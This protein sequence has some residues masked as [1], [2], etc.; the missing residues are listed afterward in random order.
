VRSRLYLRLLVVALLVLF[1]PVAGVWS[2][3][4]FEKE[5]LAAEERAMATQARTFAA[6]L[7]PRLDPAGAL[8]SR[9]SEARAALRGVERPLAGRVRVVAADGALLAD[10]ADVPVSTTSKVPESSV[11]DRPLYRIGALLWS[12]RRMFSPA[13]QAPSKSDGT[14]PGDREAVAA[15]LGGGYGAV[16]RP[17]VD[18]TDTVLTVAVPIRGVPPAVAELPPA[19][20]VGAVVVSR[21]TDTVLAALDRIRIDLFRVV[22]L[23]LVATFLIALLLARGLV[24]P[25]LRLRDAAD[26]ALAAPS[27]V[28]TPV[29]EIER[30]DEIGEVAR[31]LDGLQR[32]LDGRLGQLESFA[33]DLAHE[34]RNPLAAMRSAADLLP[35]SATDEERRHLAALIRAEAVRVDRIVTSLQ[36]LAR[37]DAERPE[38]GA[39]RADLAV[40]A[41]RVIEVQRT[42][43]ARR[44]IELT[45]PDSAL[46]AIPEEAAERVVENLLENALSFSPAGGTVRVEL[47]TAARAWELTVSDEG[48]GVPPEHRERIFERFFSW[49]PEEGDRRHLGLGLAIV[50]ALLERHGGSIE[51]DSGP[52][53][54]E[55]SG[56]APGGARFRVR[57]PRFAGG[58]G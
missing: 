37:L 53:P 28:A 47:A 12:V 23:S 24:L 51:L 32:R 43:A 29:P 16:T 57:I 13:A 18:G 27:R 30:R 15:A 45:A 20:V 40:V 38:R 21:T 5:L 7:A 44:A 46:A 33:T 52:A 49:R 35:E 1:L 11:R 25:L 8:A 39:A 55:A 58:S 48:P 4:S 17:S 19:A 26:R 50:R 42:G 41:R 34:L 56:G 54:A 2:L 22:L 3:A 14:D 36:D 6:W 10:T 9:Q 31:A